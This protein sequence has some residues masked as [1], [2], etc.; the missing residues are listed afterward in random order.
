MWIILL[1]KWTREI[2]NTVKVGK[3]ELQVFCVC[4]CGGG[5]ASDYGVTGD[6]GVEMVTGTVGWADEDRLDFMCAN[7]QVE[8]TKLLKDFTLWT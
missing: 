5:D 1:W 8:E 2:S 7:N 6:G 3:R 4:V